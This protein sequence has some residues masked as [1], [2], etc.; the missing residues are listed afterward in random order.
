MKNT[1]LHFDN[2]VAGQRLVCWIM[3]ALTALDAV[4]MLVLYLTY[5]R[6]KKETA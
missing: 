2:Y 3:V 6:K 4:L 5:G 1:S